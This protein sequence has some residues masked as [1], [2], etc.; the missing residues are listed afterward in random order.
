MS[1]FIGTSEVL[2]AEQLMKHKLRYYAVFGRVSIEDS[3]V[4][5]LE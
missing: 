5:I 1:G 4:F 2:K 3:G